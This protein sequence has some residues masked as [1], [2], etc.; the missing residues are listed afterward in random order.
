MAQAG[1]VVDRV[2][3]GF[4]EVDLKVEGVGEGMGE[5][6]V[7]GHVCCSRCRLDDGTLALGLGPLGVRPS[8]GLAEDQRGLEGEPPV[9]VGKHLQTRGLWCPRAPNGTL[10]QLGQLDV[11]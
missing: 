11:R 1:G 7:V 9:D 3:D 5:G 8:R 10:C 2:L 6:M 4:V